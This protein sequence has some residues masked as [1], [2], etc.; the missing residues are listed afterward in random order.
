MRT[1]VW[2]L[3]LSLLAVMLAALLRYTPGYVLVVIPPYRIELSSGMAALLVLA[4]FAIGHLLLR[5]GSRLA[6]WPAE[7]RA[8]RA[9]ERR[10]RADAALAAAVKA[11]LAQRPEQALAQAQ[12]AIDGGADPVASALL[13]AQAAHALGDAAARDG[14]LA[15]ARALDEADPAPRLECERRWACVPPPPVDALPA[16]DASAARDRIPA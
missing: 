1:L 5:A 3:L 6:A 13:A 16:P 15:R 14:W 12:Q 4:L 7:A 2:I 10:A 8:W 11:H 9:R